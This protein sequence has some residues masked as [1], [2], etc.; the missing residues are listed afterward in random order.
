M[1][2]LKEN[3]KSR[4]NKIRPAKSP[5]FLVHHNQAVKVILL[6]F[7]L[8]KVYLITKYLLPEKK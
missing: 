1:L 6:G 2:T 3:L 7:F 4:P 8:Q 5:N